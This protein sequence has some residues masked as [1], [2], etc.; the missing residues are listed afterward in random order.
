M[1]EIGS[2]SFNFDYK[3]IIRVPSKEL[4]AS[5][6][7]TLELAIEVGAE[8][9]IADNPEVES[10]TMPPDHDVKS[11]TK[12]HDHDINSFAKS[13]DH[14]VQQS[15]T[16]SPDNI[17]STTYDA[18]VSSSGEEECCQF[19]CEPRDLKRVSDA[20]RNKSFTISSASLEYI[21]KT[22]VL[23]KQEDFDKAV[24][25]VNLLSEREE[26]MEVYDDFALSD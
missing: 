17:E 25:L 23:L 13:H 12:S 9:V 4:L 24:S 26:V 5:H 18:S 11:T 1:G 3:G 7:D 10:S 16:K 20:I 2:S 8:D 21:P 22:H 19:S 6:A 15:T 14:S